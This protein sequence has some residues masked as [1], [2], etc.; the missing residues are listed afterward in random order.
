MDRELMNA[1]QKSK[2]TR[3]YIDIDVDFNLN[4]KDSVIIN[5][6]VDD[7]RKKEIKFFVIETKGGYHLLLKKETVRFNYNELVERWN[8][9]GFLGVKEIVVNKNEMIPL[10][11]CY[12]AGFPVLIR[13]ELSNL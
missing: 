3:H 8:T 5:R 10:S 1:I 6:L 2:G 12:Q 4:M 7:L 11:G 9:E 13:W